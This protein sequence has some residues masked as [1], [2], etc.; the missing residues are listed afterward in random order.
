MT[1]EKRAN[2]VKRSSY[3]QGIQLQIKYVRLSSLTFADVG[4]PVT[5]H[6]FKRAARYIDPCPIRL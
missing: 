5:H 6:S 4:Q 1:T 2:N 3:H